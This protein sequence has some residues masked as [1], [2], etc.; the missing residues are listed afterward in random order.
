MPSPSIHRHP[1]F[2]FLDMCFYDHRHPHFTL[3]RLITATRSRLETPEYRCESST[4]PSPEHHRYHR[5]PCT[6]SLTKQ[7]LAERQRSSRRPTSHSKIG[8][9]SINANITRLLPPFTHPPTKGTTPHY[10]LPPDFSVP[11]HR[12]PSHILVSHPQLCYSG[13]EEFGRRPGHPINALAGWLAHVDRECLSSDG[14]RYGIGRK[15]TDRP[16]MC[17]V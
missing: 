1:F 6:I 3:A 4:S 16:G 17:C 15:G 10:T 5:I 11:Q 8:R 9:P 2:L 7:R 12:H 13:S 14:A